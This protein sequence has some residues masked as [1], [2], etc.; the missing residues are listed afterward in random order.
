MPNASNID[1]ARRAALDRIEQSHRNARIA[2]F[3]AALVEASFLAGFF[4]LADLS[5][6]THVLL[7]LATVAIYT[8][9]ALGLVVLGSH[10][11]RNTL[12]IL[13]AIELNSKRE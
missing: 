3:S 10:M 13:E 9:V 7:L 2:F 11:S 5:N 8:I 12:R 6:R 1:A 4:L